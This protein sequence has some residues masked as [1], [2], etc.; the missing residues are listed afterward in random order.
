MN[1]ISFTDRSA[2]FSVQS[3]GPPRFD[4]VTITVIITAELIRV[5]R[6]VKKES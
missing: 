5:V 4:P 3:S 1:M 2:L 6:T